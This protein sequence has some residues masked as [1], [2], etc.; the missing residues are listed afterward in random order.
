[1]TFLHYLRIFQDSI[2]SKLVNPKNTTQIC[3]ACGNKVPKSLSV[4]THKCPGLELDRDVNA[5]INIQQK[6]GQ[7][8]P[9]FKLVGMFVGTS[10]K[11]DAPVM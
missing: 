10:A 4:R 9:D 1:M 11:Q 3:S 8:M 6:V 7:D 5:A 2:R